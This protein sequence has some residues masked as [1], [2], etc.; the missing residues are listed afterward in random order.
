[1]QS[2]PF[3]ASAAR[4]I[5]TAAALALAVT[6]SAVAAGPGYG[7]GEP[8]V[9][10]PVGFSSVLTAR[11]VTNHGGS[12][13]V[14]YANGALTVNIPKN[15]TQ[16]PVQIAITNGR[17]R[18]VKGDLPASLDRYSIVTSFGVEVQSSS[19]ATKTTK[20]VTIRF[21]A[22][23]LK[24]GDVVLVYSAKTG[25]FTKLAGAVVHN[26]KVVISLKSGES[27]AVVAPPRRK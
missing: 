7:G 18:T 14:K 17:N 16:S 6:G 21:S 27:L 2:K 15:A 19:S 20:S 25:K 24:K 8:P 5:T 1:M 4:C 23:Y 3:H 9:V 12:F 26:G 10:T 13:G 22:S 11:T